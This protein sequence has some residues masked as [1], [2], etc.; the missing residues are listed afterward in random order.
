MPDRTF[1]I[2]YGFWRPLFTVLGLGPRFSRVELRDGTLHVRMGWAFSAAVAAVTI[3]S[4]EVERRRIWWSIGVHGFAGRWLVNGSAL[5]IVWVE[6][7]PVQRARVLGVPV[8][9]RWL[10]LSLEEPEAFMDAVCG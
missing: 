10:G 5:G 1:L 9:L 7:K 6:F 3:E 4:C 8:K 2:K